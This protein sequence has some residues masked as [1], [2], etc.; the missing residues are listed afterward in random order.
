MQAV[1][2]G[3]EKALG[4][5]LYLKFNSSGKI[6]K[7][8]LPFRTIKWD[9]GISQER[10]FMKHFKKLLD[11]NWIGFNN[12]TGYYFIRGFDRLRIEYNYKSRQAVTLQ[13]HDLRVLKAF[14]VAAIIGSKVNLQK[15]YW[16]YVAKRKLKP[17]AN[18]R[19]ATS[20]AKVY[21]N[22]VPPE[23]HGLGLN[24]IAKLLGCKKTRASQL[25]N[26]AAKAGFIK[27]NHKFS[28]LT[29]LPAVDW[30]IRN[31]LQ[32]LDPSLKGKIRF[33]VITVKKMKF[34]SVLIQKHDEIIPKLKFLS[35]NKFNNL[36]VPNCVK[37]AIF[38]KRGEGSCFNGDTAILN[39]SSIASL[40][41]HPLL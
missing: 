32:D 21:V 11:A 4:I 25:K 8:A 2:Q 41:N 26:S 5:F 3:M 18:K 29:R 9:L 20:P 16:Q 6:H 33:K 27:V 30:K 31:Y 35:I 28:E 7:D 15:Y 14:L 23:Y 40:P 10:T 1:T 12:I 36:V 38:S 39:S 24:G 37:K 13:Y 17:V 22:Q 34:I 19:D